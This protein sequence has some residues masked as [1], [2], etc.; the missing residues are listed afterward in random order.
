MRAQDMT[1]R[2]PLPKS[3][4]FNVRGTLATALQEDHTYYSSK[5]TY[6]CWSR[7]GMRTNDG[8]QRLWGLGVFLALDRAL[9]WVVRDLLGSAFPH[10]VVGFVGGLLL[11]LSLQSRFARVQ[12]R[13]AT[14]RRAWPSPCNAVT[15]R[16]Y[17]NSNRSR[18]CTA[19]VRWPVHISLAAR[20]CR[21]PLA[22]IADKAD[23]F[24]SPAAR[25]LQVR[26]GGPVPFAAAALTRVRCSLSRHSQQRRR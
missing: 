1:P 26:C 22:H 14:R 21:R 18:P 11:L 7:H 19:S 8:W 23:A 25:L 15:W 9:R 17:R 20:V 12:L 13:H 16:L 6:A 4:G 24:L 5:Y 2:P 10:P 3:L